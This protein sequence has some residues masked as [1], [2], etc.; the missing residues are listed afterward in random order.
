MFKLILLIASLQGS[1]I[2][3]VEVPL[4]FINKSE[5]ADAAPRAA[6]IVTQVLDDQYQEHKFEVVGFKC[7][8]G[9]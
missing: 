7:E 6:A 8:A 9:A 5:C 1:P 4:S 3:T 2:G